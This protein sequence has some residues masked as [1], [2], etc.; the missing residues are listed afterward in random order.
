[1]SLILSKLL[2][3]YGEVRARTENL[4]STL[5]P[6]DFVV[7]TME[8]VS[9]TKW[10]LAHTSWFFEAFV[11][12]EAI[13]GYKPFHPQYHHLFNSYYKTLGEPFL[14]PN[15][16][17]LSRPTVEEIFAFRHAVDERIRNWFESA[18]DEE[19]ERFSPIVEIGLNHEQQHQE[20][21]LT[22]IKHV[23]SVNPLC[24][25]FRDTA[26]QA[27]PEPVEQS[28]M[29]IEEGVYEIGHSGDGFHYDNEGPRHKQYIPDI[30]IA[31]RTVTNREYLEFINDG[32]YQRI[33]C[34]LSEGWDAICQHQWQAP[35][36]WRRIDGEWHEFTLSGL[37]ALDLNAPV[38]HLS[39]YEA[40]A[41]AR[42][43]GCRLPTE[44]EWEAAAGDQ[45][46]EGNFLENDRFHPTPAY[47]DS[48]QRLLQL[49]GNVWEWTQSAYSPYP[50]FRAPRGAIGEYN[51]KWMCNQY[52]LRGGSCATPQS[53]L[54]K[55]YRNFF[56][57]RSRWQF[58]GIRLIREGR[59]HANHC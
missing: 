52:V 28:W 3:T 31:R 55:S 37:R 26:E 42:W 10:H 51:G 40:S 43:A 21:L 41:F 59:P 29:R 20:L 36:Y 4:C 33:E 22:D 56:P 34:W 18:S 58:A 45:P 23:L 35:I 13:S 5:K 54:R 46:V 30:E 8:D 53:H 15:R 2:H 7:Q 24:P 17:L 19:L 25:V 27:R 38:C 39:Y 16:G 14:R 49:F 6:E 11:L 57:S 50:G 44:F 12:N 32:G 9:P 1:M 48:S 47:Q